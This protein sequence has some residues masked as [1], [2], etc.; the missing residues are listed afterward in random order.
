[1][2]KK[3]KKPQKGQKFTIVQLYD[4]IECTVIDK[5]NCE[6]ANCSSA[7]RNGRRCRWNRSASS[8]NG[9]TSI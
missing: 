7:M 3:L 9:I 4:N 8:I 5:N 2:G 6:G 1:M